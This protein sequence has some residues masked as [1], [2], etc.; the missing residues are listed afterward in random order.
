QLRAHDR[1]YRHPASLVTLLG[2]HDVPRF[3]SEPGATVAGLRLAYTFL[4]TARGTPL[5]Y[6]GD[7]IAL[8]GG[9]DPDNRRDFPG[10]WPGD[11][12]NAFEARGRTPEEE[13]IHAHVTK[14]I[15]LRT[16]IAP[17]SRGRELNVAARADGCGCH[18]V[19]T[20]V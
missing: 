10:G 20:D 2:L 1:L 15:H 12:R 18:S 9:G 3:M 16:Q 19:T 13:A 5:V 14:L 7:E 17:L 4:L 11:P 8:P 6:Y